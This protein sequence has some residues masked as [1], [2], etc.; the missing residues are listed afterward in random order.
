MTPQLQQALGNPDI[1]IL[2]LIKSKVGADLAP[3]VERDPVFDCY[4]PLVVAPPG[5]ASGSGV[6]TNADQ[7]Y[8]FYGQ[9]TVSWSK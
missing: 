2:S 4:D 1:D 3:I 9:A 7:P 6:V 5:P 8:P